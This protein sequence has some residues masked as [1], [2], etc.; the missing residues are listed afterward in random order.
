V[1]QQRLLSFGETGKSGE[2]PSIYRKN[3]PD[4]PRFPSGEFFRAQFLCP[5]S[6]LLITTERV[7]PTKSFRILHEFSSASANNIPTR[8][9]IQYSSFNSAVLV[10]EEL[11]CSP[12]YNVINLYMNMFYDKADYNNKTIKEIF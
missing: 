11:P 1:K 6:T 10:R 2:N 12:G 8:L 3:S 4:R 9:D 5:L 7:M